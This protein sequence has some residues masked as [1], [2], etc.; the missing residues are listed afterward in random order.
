MTSTDLLTSSNV[1]QLH[2]LQLFEC[3]RFVDVKNVIWLVMKLCSLLRIYRFE[4]IYV[5]GLQGKTRGS[6]SF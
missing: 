2:T 6:R 5:C 4:G 3:L 1:S